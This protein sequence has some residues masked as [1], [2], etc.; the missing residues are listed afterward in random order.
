MNLQIETNHS[1]RAMTSKLSDDALSLPMFSHARELSYVNSTAD[2]GG[3]IIVWETDTFTQV[4]ELQGHKLGVS[5][6]TCCSTSGGSSTINSTS[7]S[8]CR[9]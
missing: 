2:G 1:Y 8:R 7:T 3:L 6:C 5:S 9:G 4:A